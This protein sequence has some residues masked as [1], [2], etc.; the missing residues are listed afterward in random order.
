MMVLSCESH[1]TG[2]MDKDRQNTL[3]IVNRWE[4]ERGKG[5]LNKVS[6]SWVRLSLTQHDYATGFF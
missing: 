2:D 5:T 6:S 3:W 4:A 1:L